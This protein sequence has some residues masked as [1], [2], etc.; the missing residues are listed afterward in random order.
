[1]EYLTL[2]IIG[3]VM[4]LFGGLL[5]IGGSLIMIPAMAMAFGENQHLYQAAAMVCNFFVATSSVI[6][7]KKART[8]IPDILKRLIPA[9]MVGILIGVAVSNLPLFAGGKS[10]LLARFFG[11]FLIYI[12]IYNCFR[13]R[14]KPQKDGTD[15]QAQLTSKQ[16]SDSGLL[17]ALSGLFTGI[18]AGLLGIG[19]G[20]IATPLQQ[21]FMKVPIKRAMSNSAATITAIALIGATYK[22]LTLPAHGIEILDSL[23]IAAVIIPTAIIGGFVGG[24]LMHKLPKNVVRAV[25]VLTLILAAI[26]MLTIKPH[27]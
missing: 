25:F 10:Y 7:H 21:L 4:G 20:T 23:K 15:L 18:G 2:I 6:A 16:Y 26:K 14:R 24:H 8:L 22:N 1:M 11:L 12:I 17:S 19:A 9:A 27:I 3:L 13:F 5:G